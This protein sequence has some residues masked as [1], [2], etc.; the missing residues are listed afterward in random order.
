MYSITIFLFE[1]FLQHKLTYGFHITLAVAVTVATQP[2]MQLKPSLSVKSKEKLFFHLWYDSFA[3]KLKQFS[4]FRQ[5]LK[6]RLF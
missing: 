6:S 2:E 1:I 3:R 5:T 4:S